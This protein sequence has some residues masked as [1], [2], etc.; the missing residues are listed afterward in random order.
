MLYANTFPTKNDIPRC[1]RVWEAENN[2]LAAKLSLTN[3]LPSPKHFNIL[4]TLIWMIVNFKDMFLMN[5]KIDSLL[6][7]SFSF[8]KNLHQSTF[9][10]NKFFVCYNINSKSALQ[11]NFYFHFFT[12]WLWIQYCCCQSRFTKLRN[13]WVLLHVQFNDYSIFG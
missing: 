3:K 2:F 8:T 11:F 7:K 4:S 10:V 13:H 12:N 6:S 1:W 5:G 9:Y